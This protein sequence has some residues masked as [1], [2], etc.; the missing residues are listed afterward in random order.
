MKRAH[1]RSV[2]EAAVVEVVDAAAVDLAVVVEAVAAA[3]VVVEDAAAVDLAVV[4]VEIAI[5]EIAGNSKK[6]T[7]SPQRHGDIEKTLISVLLCLCG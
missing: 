2:A 5:E 1:A 7:D 6:Q 3:A 4:E